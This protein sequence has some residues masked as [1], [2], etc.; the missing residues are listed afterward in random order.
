MAV[1]AGSF[2][3]LPA[4]AAPAVAT[5]PESGG[6]VSTHGS[7]LYPKESRTGSIEALSSL[8]SQ[9]RK[10]GH[11]EAQPQATMDTM[12]IESGSPKQASSG[13]FLM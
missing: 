12:D 8:F 6:P 13:S 2:T 1:D 3:Q 11:P 10:Q 5:V 4:R 9:Q 7:G